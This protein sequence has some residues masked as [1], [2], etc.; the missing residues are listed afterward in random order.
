VL[1]VDAGTAAPELPNMIVPGEVPDLK[2]STGVRFITVASVVRVHLK[3]VIS[4][5][6]GTKKE[7]FCPTAG[8]VAAIDMA[9]MSIYLVNFNG[10]RLYC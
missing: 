6:V 3:T 4:M 2:F 9:G 8:E 1:T 7:K 5:S 10:S